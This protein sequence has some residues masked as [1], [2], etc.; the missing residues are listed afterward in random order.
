V[1]IGATA[2]AVMIDALSD[3]EPTITELQKI[4]GLGFRSVSLYMTAL[5]RRKL[6]RV[7]GWKRDV[8]GRQWVRCWSMNPDGLRDLPKPPRTPKQEIDRRHT[9]RVRQL[10]VLHRMAGPIEGA[11]L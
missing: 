6:V 1:T 5:H 3:D 2:F 9:E 10:R 11:Q 4:T 8:A 7:C